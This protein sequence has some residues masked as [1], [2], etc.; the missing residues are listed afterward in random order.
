MS[1][2]SLL[3]LPP[4]PSFLLRHIRAPHRTTIRLEKQF[5]AQLD[6]LAKKSG[7]NWRELV[8]HEL[9]SKPDGQ[10]AASWLRV[11]CLLL[12]MKGAKNGG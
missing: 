3:S 8:E 1:R 4:F 6:R 11:R 2:C 7:R 9:A 10:G 12:T 5:W